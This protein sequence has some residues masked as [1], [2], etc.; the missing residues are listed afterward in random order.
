MDDTTPD[1]R[2]AEKS[3]DNY[4]A[5]QR[6]GSPGPGPLIYLLLLFVIANIGGFRDARPTWGDE[7]F[8]L[9]LANESWSQF[10]QEIV[11]DVHPPLYFALSKLAADVSGAHSTAPG[12]VRLLACVFFAILI[13]QTLRLLYRRIGNVE[14]FLASGILL[15]LSAHLSLFG[16]MLRYY[17]LS[18]I[19]AVCSTL[20]LLPE[21]GGDQKRPDN[22]VSRAIW[23]CV[24]LLVAFWSSYITAVIIPA[25]LIFL[26]NGS[27]KKRIPLKIAFGIAIILSIPLIFLLAKQV[28]GHHGSEAVAAA[29]LVKGFI[30]RLGF[31]IYSFSFGEFIRPW[32]WPAI[33]AFLSI[34]LLLIP[35]WK[36]RKT[37]LGSL[38]ILTLLIGIPFGVIILAVTGVGIEFSASRLMFLAPLLLILLGIGVSEYPKRTRLHLVTV[39]A[40][41]VLVLINLYS[42]V[43]YINGTG[44]VQSTYVIPWGKIG[45]DVCRQTVD[46]SFLWTDD[47][48]LPYWISCESQFSGT[49]NINLVRKSI[50][51]Y[52]PLFNEVILVYSPGNDSI[53]ENLDWLL[54]GIEQRYRLLDEKQY[55]VEDET[56]LRW[57]TML[58]GRPV[59][60]VK[61]V[62]RVYVPAGE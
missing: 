50:G 43:N 49:E 22:E 48:T 9:R 37:E 44:Y 41:C 40:L 62:M 35:A 4:P 2:P 18:G 46:G 47:D 8:T 54:Q 55:L 53:R 7:T 5:R 32:T 57:K 26:F 15:C 16:P 56:S 10:R 23:Y 34:I 14:A 61:K 42:T 13:V 31:V 11:S 24:A 6:G 60:A 58:L 36:S 20:L 51:G 33:P 1:G 21:K 28:A 59:E 39:P 19:G 29:G 12:G 30:G 45:N 27:R 17:A 38:L 52:Q 3:N 25:H